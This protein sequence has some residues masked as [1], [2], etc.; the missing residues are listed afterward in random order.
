MFTK[1]HQRALIPLVKELQWAV[2][3]IGLIIILRRVCCGFGRGVLPILLSE[4]VQ[5]LVGK[6]K[7]QKL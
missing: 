3:L 7:E 1:R 6:F 5:R 2:G 4:Q